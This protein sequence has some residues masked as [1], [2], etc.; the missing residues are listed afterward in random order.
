MQTLDI[1]FICTMFTTSAALLKFLLTCKA[2]I[3]F[4]FLNYY[5]LERSLGKWEQ[6]TSVLMDYPSLLRHL[7]IVQSPVQTPPFQDPFCPPLLPLVLSLSS[8][9]CF[10]ESRV[11]IV[12]DYQNGSD[13]FPHLPAF[14]LLNSCQNSYLIWCTSFQV[15]LGFPSQ[16]KISKDSLS[17]CNRAACSV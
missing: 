2:G 6:T 8:C 11:K 7:P 14:A 1:N 12:L 17:W 4:P 10:L 15:L 16:Q 9:A 13:V 3:I 5:L